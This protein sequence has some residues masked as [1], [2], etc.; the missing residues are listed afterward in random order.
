M[1]IWCSKRCVFIHGNVI[2]FPWYCLDIFYVY[3]PVRLE[4]TCGKKGFDKFLLTQDIRVRSKSNAVLVHVCCLLSRMYEWYM[5]TKY[6][7]RKLKQNI[8][9]LYELY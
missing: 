1:F 2:V 4:G 5:Y 7:D 8:L 3:I 9:D 6:V